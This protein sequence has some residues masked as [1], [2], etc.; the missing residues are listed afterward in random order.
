MTGRQV[1]FQIQAVFGASGPDILVG[2][3]DIE[4]D[5]SDPQEPDR[6]NDEEH[7][8]VAVSE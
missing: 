5:A 8:Y 4:I 7:R 6:W 1:A 2:P 3:E